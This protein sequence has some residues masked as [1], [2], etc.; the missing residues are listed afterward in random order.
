[1]LF[2]SGACQTMTLP[3]HSQ[4][5][6]LF[7]RC[8]NAC[9]RKAPRRKAKKLGK[10]YTGMRGDAGNKE[11]MQRKYTKISTCST[12]RMTG[13][14]HSS[15]AMWDGGSGLHWLPKECKNPFTDKH[16]ATTTV[17]HVFVT[18]STQ[19]EMTK[20]KGKLIWVNIQQGEHPAAV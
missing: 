7:P 9:E 2:D 15:H 13:L 17:I 20:P 12:I 10:V 3:C 6:L 5:C 8:P 16:G 19:G 14:Y 11:N 18:C 4:N 1:M